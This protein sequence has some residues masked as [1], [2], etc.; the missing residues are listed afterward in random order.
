MWVPDDLESR[1]GPHAELVILVSTELDAT[2]TQTSSDIEVR[3]LR[4]S[5]TL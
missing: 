3:G 4:C 1:K 5:E 2:V